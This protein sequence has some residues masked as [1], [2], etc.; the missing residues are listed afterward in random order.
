[1][2]KKIS[3]II[4][5]YMNLN[6]IKDCLSSIYKF[7]DIGNELEVIIVDNSPENTII[8]YVKKEWESVIVV[9]NEN[10]GFGEANNV[11]ARI[12]RGNVILF[13]NPDTILVEPLFS[14]ALEKF[15]ES[16]EV[17]LF[18][19]KLIDKKFKRNMSYYLIDSAGFVPSQINKICNKLDIFIDGKMFISGANIFILKDIFFEIGMFDEEIFM[20]YEESDLIKRLRNKGYKTAYFKEKRIIHLEGKSSNNNFNALERRMN[21]L[22]YY[23]MKYDQNFSEYLE[24]EINYLRLKTVVYNLFRNDVRNL[25]KSIKI[26]ESYNK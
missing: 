6:I 18:G 10:N 16:R 20:Y 7:N 21:S 12:A 8:N 19:L 25:K 3:V 11:G 4:V 2:G 22:K 1:M 5:S 9:K 15:D 24:K 17:A 13:L 23:C 26:L 14:F